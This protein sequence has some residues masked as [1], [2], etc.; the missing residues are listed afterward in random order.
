MTEPLSEPNSMNRREFGAVWAAALVAA[1]SRSMPETPKSNMVSTDHPRV[2][3]CD[4]AYNKAWK[5]A[6]AWVAK[7]TLDEKISQTGNNA[8]AIKRI[9]LPAYQYYAGEALHGLRRL[10]PVTLFPGL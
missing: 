9:G 3:I 6:A 7:M 8:P 4:E 2:G 5:R 10:P 1:G